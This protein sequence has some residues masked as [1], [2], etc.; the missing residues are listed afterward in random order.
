MRSAKYM[1]YWQNLDREKELNGE[2]IL[3]PWEFWIIL[4]ED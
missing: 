3:K 1:L 2:I 4:K